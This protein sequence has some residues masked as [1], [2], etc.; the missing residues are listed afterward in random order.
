[1]GGVFCSNWERIE[2]EVEVLAVHGVAFLHF[3]HLVQQQLGK[4]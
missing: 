2:R 1:V 4:N 3:G